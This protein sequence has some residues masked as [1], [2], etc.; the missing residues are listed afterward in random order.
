MIVF[1]L[2]NQAKIINK[3]RFRIKQE[4]NQQEET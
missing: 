2:K 1:L 4:G 3:I